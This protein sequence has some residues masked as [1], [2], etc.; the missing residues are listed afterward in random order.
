[1]PPEF[2]SS[3]SSTLRNAKDRVSIVGGEHRRDEGDVPSTCDV[4]EFGDTHL[5]RD[6]NSVSE[7]KR[8]GRGIQRSPETEVDSPSPILH[9]EPLQIRSLPQ[10]RLL[11][12]KEPVEPQVAVRMSPSGK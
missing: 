5:A 1:M 6:M 10:H 3:S 4:F 8:G 12:M 7:K 11:Q 9:L 2:V